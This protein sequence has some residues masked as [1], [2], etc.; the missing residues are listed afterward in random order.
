MKRKN[1]GYS[2]IEL[3][4]ALTVGA[5]ITAVALTT[6][7]GVNESKRD[8]D[9][10]SQVA[11]LSQAAA[12]YARPGAV[13][14]PNVEADLIASGRIPSDWVDGRDAANPRLVGPWGGQIQMDTAYLIGNAAYPDAI[15]LRLSGMTPS[16]CAR[17]LMLLAPTATLIAEGGPS[18]PAFVDAEGTLEPTQ[19][20]AVEACQ[21]AGAN[22][23][24]VRLPIP[25]A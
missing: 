14:T 7:K 9:V 3:A 12:V 21:G 22:V 18:G 16:S 5:V 11:Y 8:Q 20:R 1:L 13:P 4:L 19:A 23:Y 6:L 25:R 10:L 2:L 24:T 17:I 15:D